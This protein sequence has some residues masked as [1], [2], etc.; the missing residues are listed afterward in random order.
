MGEHKHTENFEE[1]FIK[2]MAEE[3]NFLEALGDDKPEELKT[4]IDAIIKILHI[5]K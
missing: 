3:A 2:D 5:I 1:N 4:H